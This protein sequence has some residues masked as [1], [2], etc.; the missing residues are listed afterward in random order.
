[1]AF[2]LH[3]CHFIDDLLQGVEVELIREGVLI[4]LK[5]HELK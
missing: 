3:Q 1:V 2:Y 5:I 4:D